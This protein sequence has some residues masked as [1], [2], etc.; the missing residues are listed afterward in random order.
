MSTLFL[1]VADK[2]SPVIHDSHIVIPAVF[3]RESSG[4]AGLDSGQKHAG[5]T[6]A[7]PAVDELTPLIQP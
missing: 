4:G 6:G 7:G 2:F 1:S 5:M 3:K